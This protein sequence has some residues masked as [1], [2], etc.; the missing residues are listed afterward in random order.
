MKILRYITIGIIV[1]SAVPMLGFAFINV[2]A[3]YSATAYRID[4][5]LFILL[6]SLYYGV[7][8][9]LLKRSTTKTQLLTRLG[10]TAFLLSILPLLAI[11]ILLYY[12]SK[13]L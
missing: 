2:F 11:G 9:Y 7:I 3:P 12:L 5:L 13:Q 10:V 4:W 1:L 6:V 8:I